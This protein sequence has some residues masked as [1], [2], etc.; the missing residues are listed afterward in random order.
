ML[1]FEEVSPFFSAIGVFQ[2]AGQCSIFAA[3]NGS[4]V[5]IGRNYDMLFSLKK[6]TESSL[7]CFD[8]EK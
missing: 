1:T 7:V 2:P 6:I 5:I 4:E 3:F 8:G